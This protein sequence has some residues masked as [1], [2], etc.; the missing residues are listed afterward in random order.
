MAA[1][2]FIRVAARVRPAP[3]ALQWVISVCDDKTLCF[4]PCFP[5]YFTFDSVFGEDVTQD[6]IFED[7]G[8]RLIDGC[9]NGCNGTIF[10]YGPT[11][12]G[13]THTMFGPPDVENCLLD[14]H[15]KGIIPRACDSLFEK[16]SVRAAEKSENFTFQ[17]SCQFVELYNEEFYD[18]LSHSQR[19]LSIESDSK[20]IH[21]VDVSEHA[22]RSAVDVMQILEMGLDARR[23]AKTAMNRESSRSHSIFTVNVKTEELVNDFLSKKSAILNLVDLAGSERQTQSKAFDDRFEEAVKIDWSLAVLWRVIRTLADVNRRDEYVPY[24]DSKLTQILQ[25]SLGG[26]SRT[27]VIVTIHP[28]QDYQLDTFPTLLFAAECR[29]IE[30]CVCAN[31]D[32]TGNTVMAYKSEITRLREEIRLTEERIRSELWSKMATIKEELEEWKE[33]AIL[34][35]KALV[36]TQNRCDFLFMQLASEMNQEDSS[37]LHE[38]MMSD[39]L[40]QLWNESNSGSTFEDVPRIKLGRNQP[41]SCYN[42]GTTKIIGGSWKRVDGKSS[43]NACKLYR[44][45]HPGKDRPEHLWRRPPQGRA[46]RKNT[47][48]EF[49]SNN[50]STCYNC[51]TTVPK[52]T[53]RR[54]EGKPA[55]NVC[56]L[57]YERNHCDRPAELIAREQQRRRRSVTK[58][59]EKPDAKVDDVMVSGSSSPPTLS[60]PATPPCVDDDVECAR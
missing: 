59:R 36:E 25:D 34:R 11:G 7:L 47:R 41:K 58:Q 31:K 60:R 28:D 38:E 24:C 23:T 29:K 27:T 30:N 33:T 45:Y 53:S 39:I 49:A 22:V 8:S 44:K 17:V 5:K 14:D 52:G 3:T 4:D 16:L 1:T 18:L 48:V 20:G 51:W 35:E 12:S 10:A 54:V 40:T 57:Y 50:E 37:Q 55:C 19:K 2:E 43:C 9:I 6:Q 26:S 15:H 56:K 32:S 21:L 46:P 42:C 13:K